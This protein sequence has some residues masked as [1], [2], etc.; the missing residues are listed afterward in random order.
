MHTL[1]DGV[2]FPFP[3]SV[4]DP[5]M[6]KNEKRKKYLRLR[7]ENIMFYRSSYREHSQT[8]RTGLNFNIFQLFKGPIVKLKILSV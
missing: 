8:H 5:L 3:G 6:I 4:L 2:G 1:N 7:F